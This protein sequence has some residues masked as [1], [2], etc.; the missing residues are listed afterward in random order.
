MSR[1][2]KKY[3]ET[4]S[5]AHRSHQSHKKSF[6]NREIRLLTRIAEENPEF[7]SNELRR[8][9]QN[10]MVK[11]PSAST[12][13][14][15]LFN[16]GLKSF[17]AR[18]KPLLTLPMMKKRMDWCKSH[19]GLPDSYWQKVLFSDECRIDL[20]NFRGR[21]TVHRRSSEN[22]YHFRFLKKTV[23]QSP[24]LMIWGCFSAQGTGRI[25]IIDGILNSDG[26]L[27]ILEE[28]MLGSAQIL[29]LAD[30]FIF[31]DDSAPIHRAKKVKKWMVNRHIEQLQWPGNSP[32]L[33]P[34]E[35]LWKILKDKVIKKNPQTLLELKR[36]L[37]WFGE[38]RLTLI[39]AK[40]W[41]FLWKIGFK[42]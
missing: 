14:R 9:L 16:Y 38:L 13:R 12:I 23:K 30:D 4:G 1:L 11:V 3:Q 8:E 6:S 40:N 32:D 15:Y 41:F 18:R 36:Q 33:N 31:Q 2:V 17:A 27:K 24:A 39:Y 21:A 28:K 34:I 10:A 25:Q 20:F 22:P 19:K 37:S 35:N 29:G 42:W 26:Y 7:T 5:T